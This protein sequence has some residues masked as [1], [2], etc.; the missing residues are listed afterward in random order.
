MLISS[1]TEVPVAPLPA[2]SGSGLG[3]ALG[4]GRSAGGPV[5][6]WI[7]EGHLEQILDNLIANALDALSPG[8]MVRLTTSATAAGVRRSEEHTSELQSRP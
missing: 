5:L 8:H 1:W 7:G 6:A 4:V 2:G 3:T